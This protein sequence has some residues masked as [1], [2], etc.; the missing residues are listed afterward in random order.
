MA[1]ANAVQNDPITRFIGVNWG[2]TNVAAIYFGNT[3]DADALFALTYTKNTSRVV[4]VY[5][6][7]GTLKWGSAVPDFCDYCFRDRS[8]N[9]FVI[10]TIGSTDPSSFSRTRMAW[11]F[12]AADGSLLWSKN[13]GGLAS[14][15][16][17]VA[18]ACDRDGNAFVVINMDGSNA[19]M[20]KYSAAGAELFHTVGAVPSIVQGGACDSSGNLYL[21]ARLGADRRVYKLDSNG[22]V[23]S[24]IAVGSS[25]NPMPTVDTEDNLYFI[26]GNT[27]FKKNAAGTTVWSKVVLGAFIPLKSYVGT[28]GSDVYVITDD[29]YTVERLRGS[30]GTTLWTS[31][32]PSDVAFGLE[33]ITGSA[34]V[35]SRGAQSFSPVDPSYVDYFHRLSAAAG[36]L[37]WSVRNTDPI[38]HALFFA[39]PDPIIIATAPRFRA[40]SS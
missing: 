29:W 34:F 27:L 19:E 33:L 10:G 22:S 15:F 25:F 14:G 21:T 1:V 28:D 12:S 11:K 39:F 18:G 38:G 2:S 9:V 8:G 24:S 32:P 23:L 17:N 6:A 35:A 20:Y 40:A 37:Q 16:G 4:R 36:V 13:Y 26:D 7:D 5:N 31:T 3:V 30:D